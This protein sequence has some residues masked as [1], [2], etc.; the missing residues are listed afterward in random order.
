[1]MTEAGALAAFLQF[2]VVLCIAISA[3]LVIARGSAMLQNTA[4]RPAWIASV[5]AAMGMLTLNVIIPLD[6]LNAALGG[7]NLWNL[8]QALAATCAFW[9]FYR[10]IRLL[11]FGAGTRQLSSW[12]LVVSLTIQAAAF[13]FIAEPEGDPT[14]FVVDHIT[15][16]ACYVYLMV[17][18]GSVALL[19][20]AS[21]WAVRARI[22]SIFVLFFI[23]YAL[24]TAAA[25]SHLFYLTLAFLE[26]APPP[27]VEQLRQAFYVMFVPGVAV[28]CVGFGTV[29][30]QSRRKTAQ[31]I[32]RVRAFRA[33]ALM[34]KTNGLPLSVA[35]NLRAATSPEPRAHAYANAT[36]IYDALLDENAILTQ[37]E[38]RLIEAINSDLLVHLGVAD[39]L[40]SLSE[41]M[42]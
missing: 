31:P 34:R 37:R 38:R 23:G 10:S 32:W 15:D 3:I 6:A 35:A 21:L 26:G 30:I 5:F 25:I 27:F 1:M 28:L 24:I 33:E 42:T 20:G 40:A 8:I 2:T 18:I 12:F 17:Y 41:V 39:E 14:T 22:R 19:A 11:A 4:A 7:R 16:P 9:F 36:A 13:A 29:F